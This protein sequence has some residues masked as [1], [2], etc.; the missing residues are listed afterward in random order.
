RKKRME[1]RTMEAAAS[2][3]GMSERTARKWQRGPLPSATKE[4]RTWRTRPDPFEKVWSTEIEPLLVADKEGKL[5]RGVIPIH[6]EDE[7]GMPDFERACAWVPADG[8][9]VADSLESWAPRSDKQALQLL[10]LPRT[11]P[12]R[13][14]LVVAASNAA[15]GVAGDAELERAGDATVF[16]ERTQIRVGSAG[17]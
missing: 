4:P 10:R 14:K 1:D 9:L 6:E 16:V 2:A 7:D 3:A 15:G 8:V 11:H 17:G 5:E 13:V 12:A